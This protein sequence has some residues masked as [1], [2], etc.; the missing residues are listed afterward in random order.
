MVVSYLFDFGFLWLDFMWA[1]RAN[2]STHIDLLLREFVPF[3]RTMAANKT[4]YGYMCIMQVYYG[5]ALHPD[6]QAVY[7]AL[8]TLPTGRSGAPGVNTGLDWFVEDLNL[9]VKTDVTD[10]ISEEQINRRISDHCFLAAADQE[11]MEFVHENREAERAR[12]KVMDADVDLIVGFLDTTV[13]KTWNQAIRRKQGGS[14]FGLDARSEKGKLPWDTI[15]RSMTTGSGGGD[16]H[17]FDYAEKH[18][19]VYAPW[20]SWQP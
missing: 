3:G 12:M 17:V 7:H 18:V 10:H 15:M 14:K 4:N 9:G 19:K 20:H 2:K 13:G 11:L 6:I 5:V 8:R 1:R 16:E